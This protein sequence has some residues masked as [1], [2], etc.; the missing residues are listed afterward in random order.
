MGHGTTTTNSPFPGF[1]KISDQIYIHHPDQH[2]KNADHD[3]L[4]PDKV[5]IFGWGDGRPRNVSKYIEGYRAL[6]PRATVV[7]VLA[8][9]FKAAYQPLHERTE[10]MMPVVDAAFPARQQRPP[11]VLLHAMS[12]AGGI[13]L[14]STLNAHLARHGT[15]L[16]H[17][18]MVLDSV[19]GGVVFHR[20]VGRWSRAMAIGMRRSLPRWVPQAVLQAAFWVFLWAHKFW[21]FV[22]RRHHAGAWSREA[23]NRHEMVP[24]PPRDDSRTAEDQHAPRRLYLYSKEDD[25]IGWEDIEEH[26]EHASKLGYHADTEMFEGSGHVDHMRHHPQKY[27]ESIARTWRRAHGAA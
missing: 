18:V 16:P 21:E 3:E 14:A 1:T 6:Y 23:V 2:D 25:I 27:W 22:L 10:G 15:P 8:T 26:A 12:N 9:T 5:I 19:P 17:R 20:Q 11:R 7:A 13:N 4:H 24:V